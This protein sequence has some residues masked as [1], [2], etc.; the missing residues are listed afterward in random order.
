LLNFQSVSSGRNKNLNDNAM[1][2]MFVAFI[3]VNQIVL[4]PS[5]AAHKKKLVPL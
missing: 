3:M 1:A 5:G 2:N 4:Q